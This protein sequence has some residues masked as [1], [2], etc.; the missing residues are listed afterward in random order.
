MHESMHY[1]LLLQGSLNVYLGE[2]GFWAFIQCKACVLPMWTHTGPQ[3]GV[4]VFIFFVV[5]LECYKT[6]EEEGLAACSLLLLRRLK[7]KRVQGKLPWPS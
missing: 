1:L 5:L 2:R 7:T 3:K 6:P 4:D